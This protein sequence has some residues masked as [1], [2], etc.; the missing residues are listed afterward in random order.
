MHDPEKA[1]ELLPA[2]PVGDDH[3]AYIYAVTAG[4]EP[5]W[6]EVT[7]HLRIR[8]MCRSTDRLLLQETFGPLHACPAANGLVD[9]DAEEL[10]A[11]L[12]FIGL[13]VQRLEA[14]DR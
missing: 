3:L 11:R 1:T 8:V 2:Q 9:E 14:G 6:G 10:A 13:Y 7:Y 5:G 4:P 12:E